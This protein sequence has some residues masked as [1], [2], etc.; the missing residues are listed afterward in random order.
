[1]RVIYMPNSGKPIPSKPVEQPKK[2]EIPPALLA[3]GTGATVVA[4][5]SAVRGWDTLMRYKWVI[6]LA[7]ILIFLIIFFA[8]KSFKGPG[9]VEDEDKE[10]TP[11][12]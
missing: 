1:M 3:G 2:P 8:W 7:I 10:E 4:G 5:Y 12:E 6:V 9:P 11:E